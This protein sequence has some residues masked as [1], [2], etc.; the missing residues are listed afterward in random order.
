MHSVSQ[1]CA[2]SYRK[3]NNPHRLL[4]TAQ[5]SVALVSSQ[6]VKWLHRGAFLLIHAHSPILKTLSACGRKG[7]RKGL[8]DSTDASNVRQ[9]ARA[10]ASEVGGDPGDA[11]VAHC[12]WPAVRE[13]AFTAMTAAEVTAAST[14]MRQCSG[15]R[16]P[17]WRGVEEGTGA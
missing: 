12:G 11:D 3:P 17:P 14:S 1:S 15:R 10:T 7:G 16:E 9:A 6:Q 8:G 5:F 4:A 2:D 13:E